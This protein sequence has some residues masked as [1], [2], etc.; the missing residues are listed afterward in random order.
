MLYEVELRK[1]RDTHRLLTS[2]E[3]HF[4]QLKEE[5]ERR[6]SAEQSQSFHR[7]EAPRVSIDSNDTFSATLCAL[8]GKMAKIQSSYKCG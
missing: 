6:L 4:S 3:K 8:L 2:A 5:G 1:H 7:V